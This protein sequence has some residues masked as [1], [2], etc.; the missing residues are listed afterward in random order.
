[1]I[2]DFRKWC[3]K[4]EDLED[5]SYFSCPEGHSL[6]LLLH[7]LR[8]GTCF[9]CDDGETTVSEP[10]ASNTSRQG[11]IAGTTDTADI[12]SMLTFIITC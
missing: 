7:Q 1:M 4:A 12:R 8:R 11:G 2:L 3:L 6:F 10:V 5:V 9:L